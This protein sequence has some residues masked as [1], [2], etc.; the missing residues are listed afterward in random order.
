M[1]RCA[2]SDVTRVPREVSLKGRPPRVCVSRALLWAVLAGAGVQAALEA[3]PG[4][5]AGALQTPSW[6][7]ERTLAVA[8]AQALGAAAA[9]PAASTGTLTITSARPDGAA[10]TLTITGTNFGPRPLVTLDLVPVTLQSVSDTQVVGSVPVDVMPAAR[11]LLTVSRGAAPGESASLRVPLGGAA[12]APEIAATSAPASPT[13][14]APPVAP[15]TAPGIAAAGAARAGLLPTGADTAAR[16]G[17]SPITLDDVDRE[18]RRTDPAGYL[19]ASRR[20]YDARRRVVHDLVTAELLTREA[21]ARGL[22]VDALLEAEIPKRVVAMPDSAVSSLYQALGERTRG[23]SLEQMR[24]ALRAWLEQITEPELAKMSYTE[25]LMK[26]STRADILLEPPAV[27]VERTTQDAMLGPS[28][29]PVEIVAFGDF[30][31][32]DYARFA[33]VFGR[34]RDTFGDR[35]R[36]VF[37]HLPVQGP[38]SVGAAQ[39]AQC[40][41]RQGRFWPFHDAVLAQPAFLDTARLKQFASQAGLDRATFD[42]CVDR[43]EARAVVSAAAE[44]AARY[45]VR[46]SPSFLVNGVLAPEPPPFLPPFEYFQRLIEEE[47]LRVS[48]PRPGR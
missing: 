20:L 27:R 9:Q 28:S 41:N 37:K 45:D 44:E 42:R 40:A 5:A 30:Q 36:I 21:E 11:Y 29:A 3:A 14:A 7:A 33:Q 10:S 13:T 6:E 24:P 22:T 43:D 46:A 38:V 1:H 23:A 17:D 16:V 4:T 15:T 31:S 8:R 12:A 25:E 34:I 47:L 48:R 35:L 19:A 2:A 18:W 32:V 26:I 39:A